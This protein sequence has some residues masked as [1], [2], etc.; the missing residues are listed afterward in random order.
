MK[1]LGQVN[2]PHFRGVFIR[3]TRTQLLQSGGLWDEANQMY[4][5]FKPRTHEQKLSMTFPS[6]SV[7]SFA[8][9]D[10]PEDRYNFDGG[11]YS[12]VVFDEAQHQQE[13]S[14]Y[15]FLQILVLNQPLIILLLI[16]GHYP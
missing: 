14:V 12:L 16:S 3:Q 15:L 6:G 11:Q 2:D 7:I 4:K 1:A 5:P 10:R 9:L 13:V 8:G